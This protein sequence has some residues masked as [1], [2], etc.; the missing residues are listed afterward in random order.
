MKIHL[1]IILPS[2]CGSPQWLFSLRFIASVKRKILRVWQIPQ[3]I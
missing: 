3:V 1:N 2:T